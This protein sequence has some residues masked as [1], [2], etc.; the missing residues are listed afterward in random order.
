MFFR[1]WNRDKGMNSENVGGGQGREG[2]ALGIGEVGRADV[3][4]GEEAALQEQ[5]VGVGIAS[6]TGVGAGERIG[7]EFGFG[8]QEF[9]FDFKHNYEQ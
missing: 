4:L 8:V 6:E 7:V 2:A 1:V 9:E 3:G 5:E